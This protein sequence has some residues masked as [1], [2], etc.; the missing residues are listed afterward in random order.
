[1]G[2]GGRPGGF[3]AWRFGSQLGKDAASKTASQK[4]DRRPENPLG[5]TTSDRDHSQPAFTNGRNLGSPPSRPH[6]GGK[7]FSRALK[8]VKPAAS[9]VSSGR[10]SPAAPQ[11]KPPLTPEQVERKTR[12]TIDEYLS[13]DD[14]TEAVECVKEIDSSKLDAFAHCA[15]GHVL[16]KT[17]QARQM[18]GRLFHRL[19][20]SKILTVDQ[21]IK[22]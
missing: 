6:A 8:Q 3:A 5:K 12:A 2:P 10:C 17:T 9:P 18:T 16:A 13:L 7:L 21:F 22:G 15:F 14:L 19:I 11:P 1:M 20:T 4:A